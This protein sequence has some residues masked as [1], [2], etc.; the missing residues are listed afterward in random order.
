[1][2]TETYIITTIL[3]VTLGV[4]LVNPFRFRRAFLVPQGFV[5]LLYHKGRF[6]ELLNPGRHIRWSRFYGQNLIDLRKTV[7]AVAG[8]EVLTADNVALK[9]SLS[10]TYQVTDPAMAVNE[11]QNWHTQFYNA[12]Q[13]AARA[14]VNS[15]AV[16]ALINQRFEIGAQLLTRVQP[17][18]AQVGVTVLAVEVKDVMF[19]ADLK[20]AFADVLKAR[21]EVQAALERAR[22]ESAALRNLANAARVLDGNP[23]LMNLRL[24]QSLATAQN[25]G[26]TLVVGMPGGFVPLNKAERN[27]PEKAGES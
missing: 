3:A 18:A 17:Q 19:P 1:M 20:R 12:V 27:A 21:Q 5:G 8:Q 6:V 15:V 11:T 14:V 25:A 9:L 26:N 4:L 23:A 16:E 13:L 7:L 22:G 2:N 24:M 10:V